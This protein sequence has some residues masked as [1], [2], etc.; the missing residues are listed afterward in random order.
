MNAGSLVHL[1]IV[2]IVVCAV[3]G[4]AYI[5]MKQAGIVIPG[6]IVQIAWIVLACVIGVIAIRYVAMYL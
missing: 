6:W 3:I 1:I 2:V 5:V 4:I